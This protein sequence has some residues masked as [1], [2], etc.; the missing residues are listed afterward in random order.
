MALDSTK[1]IL[2]L[3]LTLATIVLT[4]FLAWLLYYLVS[5]IRQAHEVM[6]E[7]SSSIEKLRGIL[8]S[9]K[10]TIGQSSSHL[11]LI[12]TAVKQLVGFY[13]ARKRRRRRDTAP[14][15]DA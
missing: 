13:A 6:R 4:F 7:V 8:D 9:I 2:Y 10:E 12:V 15:D 5:I 3:A 14:N 1:D 11:A